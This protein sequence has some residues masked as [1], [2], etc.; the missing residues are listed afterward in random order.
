MTLSEGQ[1]LT[2]NLDFRTHIW[3][4]RAE[5]TPKSGPLE[6]KNNAQTLPEQIQKQLSKSPENFFFYPKNDQNTGV[7]IGKKGRFLGQ[8][9]RFKL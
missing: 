6:A 2:K 3:T 4:F 8:F 5:N 1:N 7:N 9:S